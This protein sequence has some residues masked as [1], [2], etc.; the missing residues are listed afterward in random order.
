[1]SRALQER[2]TIRMT[3]EMISRIDEWIATQPDYVSRQDAIR[4][5]VDLVLGS[6]EHDYDR[7]GSADSNSAPFV[8]NSPA[9]AVMDAS[10]S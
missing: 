3:T 10:N 4:R 6:T 7:S 2:I 9:A 1:M 8:E 5:C